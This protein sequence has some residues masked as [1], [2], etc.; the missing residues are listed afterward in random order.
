M[1]TLADKYLSILK[2]SLLNELYLEDEARI[3]YLVTKELFGMKVP[4]HEWG[5][6]LI[7]IKTLSLYD[8]LKRSRQVGGYLKIPS[9]EY[10]RN[11]LET[12]HTMIGRA[13]LDN[14]HTCMDRIVAD[15]IDGDFIETGVWKGGATI[16]MRGFLQAHDIRDRI[17]WVAD[18]FE[19]LPKP[20][21]AEDQGWDLSKETMPFLAVSLEDVQELFARYEL[22]DNQVRF[23]QGW[24]KDTLPDAP[25]GRLALLRL[26]GDLYES[27]DDAIQALYPKLALGGFL[28]IDDYNLPPCE[29]AIANYRAAHG[30]TDAIVQIDEQ[31]AYWRKSA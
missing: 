25:I 17:V 11:F 2:K 3:A 6:N 8:L 9:H 21:R 28:I 16:F 26:D 15:G 5:H 1:P 27:T 10:S 20:T 4:I 14:L 24:F 19:G 31:S 7:N 23:L 30:I 22:L 29:R 18:S 13:R 12:P